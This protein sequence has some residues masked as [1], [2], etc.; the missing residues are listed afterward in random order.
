MLV[1]ALLAATPAWAAVWPERVPAPLINAGPVEYFVKLDGRW[2][3]SPTATGIPVFYV[4]LTG[5]RAPLAA[6]SGCRRADGQSMPFTRWAFYAGPQFS[7]VYGLRSAVVQRE[8]G[9]TG[10]V[11]FADLE[12]VHGN[13]VCTGEVSAPDLS[14]PPPP[15]TGE[16]FRNGFEGLFAS[17]L[18]P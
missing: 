18:E 2:Y 14:P 13:V 15:S 9:P 16:I 3:S 1:G 7:P 12:S 6:M 10:R 5:V 8:Q 17:G 11:T 4:D